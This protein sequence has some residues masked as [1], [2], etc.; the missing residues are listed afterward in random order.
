MVDLS[1]HVDSILEGNG[2]LIIQDASRDLLPKESFPFLDLQSRAQGPNSVKAVLMM[3]S[4]QRNTE[5]I[6]QVVLREDLESQTLLHVVK[7]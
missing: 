5:R 2:S 1:F 4:E 3:K 7:G 6:L